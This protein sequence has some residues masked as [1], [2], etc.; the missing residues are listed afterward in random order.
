[1][2]QGGASPV[3]RLLQ[4]GHVSFGGCPRTDKSSFE[5]ARIIADRSV[6][7]DPS[8]CTFGEEKG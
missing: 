5:H 3:E 1:M 6:Q 4:H 7:C 8:I 2:D